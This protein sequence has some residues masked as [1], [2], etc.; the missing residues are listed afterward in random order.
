M[1]LD[2]RIYWKWR[3]DARELPLT[4]EHWELYRLLHVDSWRRAGRLPELRR[5]SS[6]NDHIQWLKLFDQDPRMVQLSDKVGVREHI[7]TR[8]GV[9]HLPELYQVASTF[10]EIDWGA[11]PDAFVITRGRSCWCPI[12]R[13]STPLPRANASNAACGAS[14]AGRRVSGPMRA[15][16]RA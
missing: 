5:P 4:A 11:M 14:S 10:D 8:V 1:L 13:A 15:S 2:L 6:F 9:R 3:Q 7:A 12:G 16:S